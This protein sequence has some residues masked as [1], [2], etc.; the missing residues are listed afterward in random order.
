MLGASATRVSKSRRRGVVEGV[1]GGPVEEVGESL[2]AELVPVAVV[3]GEDLG[4]GRCED[5]VEAADHRERQDDAP[6][7]GLLVVAAEQ[8]GDGPD[9]VGQ[10]RVMFHSPPSGV[11][12]TTSLQR[13]WMGGT[14][15]W[16]LG[17]RVRWL[18]LASNWWFEIKGGP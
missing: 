17:V 12:A 11:L 8:I 10:L 9:E 14:G 16:S 18:R 4:L 6:V 2:V 5:R 13:A 1:P 15:Q 3:L 7:L